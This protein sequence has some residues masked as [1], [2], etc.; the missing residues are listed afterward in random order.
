VLELERA[1]DRRRRGDVSEPAVEIER[2]GFGAIAFELLLPR[3]ARESFV[4]TLPNEARRH[5]LARDEP[6]LVADAVC[7]IDYAA[8]HEREPELPELGNGIRFLAHGDALE[9]RCKGVRAHSH[10]IT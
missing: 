5:L 1:Q 8:K 2:F 7:S 10:T 6:N 4:E 3:A 9:I